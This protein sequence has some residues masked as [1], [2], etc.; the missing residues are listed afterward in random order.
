MLPAQ[1]IE[2]SEAQA[3]SLRAAAGSER[4]SPPG[5]RHEPPIEP[6]TD[7]RQPGRAASRLKHHDQGNDG[8][9]DTGDEPLQ[10]EFE[11]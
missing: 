2:L 7:H 10:E 1:T 8:N 11:R 4:R 6:S 9:G 3:T 5:A